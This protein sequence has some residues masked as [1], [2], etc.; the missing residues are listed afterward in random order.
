MTI[1]TANTTRHLYSARERNVKLTFVFQRQF[2]KCTL[3]YEIAKS[4]V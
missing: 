2:V 3:R 4:N 1:T